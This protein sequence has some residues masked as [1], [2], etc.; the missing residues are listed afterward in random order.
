M[1]TAAL[2]VAVVEKN[3]PTKRVIQRNVGPQIFLF[4]EAG[5]I[6]HCD[7]NTLSTKLAL[8]TGQILPL[9]SCVPTYA[10]VDMEV[11]QAPQLHRV[12][13]PP[14]FRAELSL[15]PGTGGPML[16]WVKDLGNCS[17]LGKR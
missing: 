14:L 13:Q 2:H 17:N 3:G 11:C 10:K 9:P 15:E 16:S 4:I 8:T 6:Y 12:A 5:Q 7:M 1:T